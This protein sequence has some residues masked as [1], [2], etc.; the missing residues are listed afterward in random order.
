MNDICAAEVR[1][2]MTKCKL[3]QAQWGIWQNERVYGEK[4]LSVISVKLKLA[5]YTAEQVRDAAD[6]VMERA[7][8]F[9]AALCQEDEICFIPGGRAVEGCVLL[10]EAAYEDA[11]KYMEE[12]DR[13][14]LDS[15]REL[16]RAETIPLRE[17]GALLYVR[18]HHILIDG[19]GMS[20]FARRV[21][22][23]LEGKEPPLSVFFSEDGFPGEEAAF[24]EDGSEELFWRE[25]FREPEF[26]AAIFPEVSKGLEKTSVRRKP[27]KGLGEEILSFAE[28]NQVTPAYVLG[29]AYALYLAEASGKG[30]AVFLMAR[31]NRREEE[32][33]TLGCYTLPVP[34]RVQVEREDTFGQLCQRVQNAARLA[35]AKKGFGLERIQK[36]LR[37]EGLSFGNVSEYSFNFY[38]RGL[39]GKAGHSLDFSVSGGITGH[40]RW[41]VFQGE[42]GPF[43]VFD[44]RDGIYDRER[45]EYFANSVEEILRQGF[46]GKRA[47]EIEIIG[48]AEKRSLLAVRGKEIPIDGEATI[49]SLFREAAARYGHRP[50]LYAG[51]AALSF[52]ELDVLSDKIA[53]G[54][55]A[56]GVESGDR[57]AFMLKRDIRLIPVILGIAKAGAAF[58]PIDPMYPGDRIRYIVTDSRAKVLISSREVEQAA[59]YGY[60][61]VEELICGGEER[62]DLPP[63]R[64]EQTAYLIYTSGTTGRPKGVMLSHR[65]IVNI[66]HPD[67]NPFNRDIVEHARGITAIGSICFDISLF[68]IFVPL[69][70]GLFVELGNEKSMLDAGELAEH[71]LRHR[72]DILHCTPSRVASY[73]GSPRFREA[74]GQVKAMLMAGEVL[75]ESLVN[76]LKERYGIRVYNGYGPTET[77]IGA[78]ITEAGD[79]QTIGAP[80]ANTGV[81]LLNK[82]GKAVPWGA[83]GEIC[84]YGDGLGT[85]YWNRPRE[86]EEKF[87]LWQGMR[88][89]RTGDLGRLDPRGRLLYHGRNDRQVKLRG[90]RIELSEIERVMGAHPDVA[91]ACCILRKIERTKRLVGFYAAGPGGSVSEENLRAFMKERLAPYM[92]P[93][94]LTALDKMPQTPGGKTDYRALEELPVAFRQTYRAPKGDKEQA[95]CHAFARVLE[96]AQVGMDDNFFELGGDSL[97]AVELIVELEKA[98]GGEA[99]GINYE[100]LFQHPTPG[101]LLSQLGSPGEGRKSYPIDGLD[102]TG[103]DAYLSCRTD[104]SR[105]ERKGLGNVLITGAT[106]YLGIHIL[107][108]LLQNPDI[109]Q[110]VYCLTRSKGK[111]SAEKRMKNS[112]F[113]YAE[114]DFEESYGPK[115]EVAEGDITRDEIFIKPFAGRIDTV[116]NAAANVAHFAYGDALDQVNRAGVRNLA[117]FALSRKALFCQISTVSVGGMCR[118]LADGRVFS[119]ENLYIGQGIYNQY[120]YSKFMAE[121]ELLRSAV[122]RGLSV[123]IMRV[124]NLQ[125]RSRDGEFQMNLKSNGFTRRLSSYIRMGAVPRSVYR[126]SVNF[127]PVDETAHMIIALAGMDC[128]CPVFHV[129]PPREVEFSRL[130]DALARQGHEVKVLED[131]GFEELL[132]SLKRTDEGRQAAEGLLTERPDGINRDIPVIQNRT[133]ELLEAAGERWLTVTDEY[134]NQY[135]SALEGM[136]MY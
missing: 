39:S 134:L 73:L 8:I 13:C 57:A 108:E 131:E 115:W 103:I 2:D 104:R 67:N 125:G 107:I 90:L 124:G 30:E 117:E 74:L 5:G 51:E 17:G 32:R 29:A 121:Y 66:V 38:P 70:N 64:Q 98:L 53:A 123:K 58:I 1:D 133:Q 24:S 12:K 120:I 52:Q 63:I 97:S 92:V 27:E 10:A 80:I 47:G 14:P 6:R 95:V 105:G 111:V 84:V 62:F 23:A 127:S 96:L 43:F 55:R 129:Y 89:Y 22:D 122:D 48:E 71:I 79:N 75:P 86:T 33:E 11:L 126:G 19:Y 56:R 102:Y 99:E 135:L 106:G 109:C 116:I 118:D 18:F 59:E 25:Y 114:A 15:P 46:G 37:E 9:S 81:V 21:A 3:N 91:Q 31:Q 88:L 34:V 112:L 45:A 83:A 77:T 136:N 82:N 68:E 35:S 72:A 7:D 26:E 78:T 85:G 4:K 20:L 36:L 60:L 119:E 54:L 28:R 110:K 93:D 101:L 100:S 76:E 132:Q 128:A 40:F 94:I 130:F 61:D 65:G 87:I 41:N 49:P 50:A 69:F 42:D 16:Y 113:Y 44:L